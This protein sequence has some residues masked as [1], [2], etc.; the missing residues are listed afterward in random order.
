MAV[1]ENPD[2]HSSRL[3]GVKQF[4]NYVV[5]SDSPYVLDIPFMESMHLSPANLSPIRLEDSDPVLDVRECQFSHA[6]AKGFKDTG[7]PRPRIPKSPKRPRC[8]ILRPSLPDHVTKRLA[9][10]SLSAQ[11]G[12]QSRVSR[13]V[14]QAINEAEGQYFGQLGEDLKAFSSHAGR[15]QVDENDVIEV[16]KRSVNMGRACLMPP[17]VNIQR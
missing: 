5:D 11:M 6:G 13:K 1:P 4:Q 8:G 15:K 14:L 17:G 7:E 3:D 16:M 2:R 10:S 12:M 9:L